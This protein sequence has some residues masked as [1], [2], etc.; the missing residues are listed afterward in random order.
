MAWAAKAWPNTRTTS[1]GPHEGT[2]KHA[3]DDVGRR[4]FG[5]VEMG[6]MF[7]VLKVRDNL[8]VDGHRLRSHRSTRP[9]GTRTAPQRT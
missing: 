3:A 7:T 2:C 5:N 8:A 4:P 6:G 9:S 1:N